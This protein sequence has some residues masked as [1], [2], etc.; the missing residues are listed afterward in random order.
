MKASWTGYMLLTNYLL[1]LGIKGKIKEIIEVTGR[2]GWRRKQLLDDLEKKRGYWK[3]EGEALDHTLHNIC[4]GRGY[5]PVI[6]QTTEL[7][8][9]LPFD[10]IVNFLLY[11]SFFSAY[12]FKI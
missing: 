11:S 7:M 1:Q 2:R 6:K 5:R 9:V 10:T 3:L 8:T 4:F 12:Y